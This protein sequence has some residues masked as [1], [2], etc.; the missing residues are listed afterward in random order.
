MKS[1]FKIY[2]AV[3]VLA[4]SAA[5]CG[6]LENNAEPEVLKDGKHVSKMVFR[7]SV[8]GY[9][10]ATVR[11]NST[12]SESS[13]TDGDVVYIAFHNGTE[14]VPG[15]AEYSES[16]GWMVSFEGDL[17]EGESQVC[18]VRFFVNPTFANENLVTI[19][20]NTEIYEDVNGSFDFGNGTIS[21]TA[22]M[23]PKT[24]RIRF[25]GTA[26]DAIHVVGI[27]TYSTFSPAGNQ[28]T[29]TH[30]SI[31]LTVGASGSTPYVYGYFTDAECKISI[32]GSDFA[33]TRTCSSSIFQ[34]GDSGYM[35]IPS[36]SSHM[37]WKTGLIITVNGVD[38]KFL[39]VGGDYPFYLLAE[40][41]M[42][43]AQY[44][45]IMGDTQSSSLFPKNKIS[46]N[47]CLTIISS[48]NNKTSLR[49]IIPTRA[50][51]QYAASG[52]PLSQG[53]S[54]SGSNIAGD[55]AWYSGNSGGRTHQVKMLTPNELGFYDMS[56]NVAEWTSTEDNGNIIVCGGCYSDTYPTCTY[57]ASR[58]INSSE[59]Y[60]GLRIGLKFQ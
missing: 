6:T 4:V 45:A 24:G 44:I 9:E 51:W 42:T 52:G 29:T 37:N 39:L 19:N 32:V 10:G 17:V 18:E 47:Q 48:I 40:T 30:P 49:F 59:T 38:F 46:Y 25:T 7:G 35:K 5:A 53:Y 16:D 34:A 58:G 8:A 31:P 15:T 36:P 54:Y 60:I 14:I 41:E 26:D 11:D 1:I 57:I 3:A 28:F 22:S 55:V 27:T 23:T 33:Y 21:V 13:W 50:F 56:G 43:E 2:L 20:S 12:K